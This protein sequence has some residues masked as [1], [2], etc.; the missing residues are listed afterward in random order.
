MIFPIYRRPGGV[1]F[2]DD[3]P[4]YL[5]MLAEVMPEQWPI[6]LFTRPADCIRYLQ[7]E[8][9]DR[10][11]D[12]WLQMDILDHWRSGQ[13]LIPQI[14]QYWREAG[15]WRFGLAQVCVVDYSMPAMNGLQVLEELGPWPG[16]R[17]LLT[18]RADEQ[19]AVQAFN[20][21]LIEQYVPKQASEISLRLTRSIQRLLDDPWGRQA[22]AWRATLSREQMAV[23]SAPQI[24]RQLQA[25][26]EAHRWIEHVVIGD[27]FGVLALDDTGRAFWLQIEH[28]SRLDE[29]VEMAASAGLSGPELQTIRA[30]HRLFDGEYHLA[31]GSDRAGLQ[32]AMV[33]GDR[34]L[35]ALSAIPDGL[36]PGVDRAYAGFLRDKVSRELDDETPLTGLCSQI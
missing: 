36:C 30:G 13:G 29:L 19:I 4:A 21:A 20:A 5:E 31:I 22:Q 1:V 18:G 16:A 7:K 14:L 17:V 11:A 34:V 35:A 27:P 24:G 8:P 10:E 3:D 6:R 33:L 32:P 23:I 28:E 9:A 12:S 26:A 2:L 25:L 15:I